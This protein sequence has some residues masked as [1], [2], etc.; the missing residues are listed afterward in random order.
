M[1]FPIISLI[2]LGIL[3]LVSA[4]AIYGVMQIWVWAWG[5][6]RYGVN[7]SQNIAAFV[8]MSLASIPALLLIFD[9][10]TTPDVE[11][12][13]YVVSDNVISGRWIDEGE[14]LIL[15]KDGTYKFTGSKKHGE[16]SW[17]RDD[18]NVTFTSSIN[19][20]YTYLR[21]IKYSGQ[22]HLIKGAESGD[23]DSWIYNNGFSK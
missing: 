7:K 19:M 4:A 5:K 11:W 12:N 20:P 3:F 2:L 23:S 14:V 10:I 13:P 17:S 16:G 6:K 22:Y 18:W 15:R 9:V 8:A 1:L 21:V